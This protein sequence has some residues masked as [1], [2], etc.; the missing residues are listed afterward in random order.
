[1]KILYYNWI[2]FDD[3]SSGGGVNIYQKNIIEEL[4]KKNED[5][6]FFISSGVEYNIL[7][8]E[9]Y[10][11][12]TQNIYANRCRT[13]KII[14]SP[15]PSPGINNMKIWENS[16]VDKKL[17]RIF[18]DFILKYG[19]FNI[20][21][22]NNLEGLAFPVLELKK[23]FPKIKFIYSLHNYYFCC[24]T[25]NLWT[26]DE[27]NCFLLNY[28]DCKKC[29]NSSR[30]LEKIKRIRFKE[31][32]KK[33]FIIL[34]FIDNVRKNLK[35]KLKYRKIA[36]EKKHIKN[37]NNLVFMDKINDYEDWR[38]LGIDIINKNIDI[39]LAVSER[40]REIAIKEGIRN[41]LIQVQYIGTKFANSIN[42][43]ENKKKIKK[44]DEI[45]ICYLGY[46][47][48]DKGYYF[49]LDALEKLENKVGEK[50]NVTLCAKI[51]DIRIMEK[52]KKLEKKLKKVIIINGY[53]HQ[54][55]KNI[56]KDIHLGV[57]PVLWED[58][59]PQV[60]FEFIGYG[61]PV[62]CSNL[63]GAS[64]LAKNKNFIFEGGNINDFNTK[65]KNILENPEI[66]EEFWQDLRKL[67]NVKEHVEDLKSI[68]LQ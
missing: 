12:E 4:I 15:I 17:K 54:D 60:T 49:L 24:P 34:K 11:I 59:L 21:H 22:F 3:F 55:L 48:K 27:K 35:N 23:E 39:I 53:T 51:V 57:I 66:L 45:N 19:E 29:V 2:Q 32:L 52:I 1:M 47:R 10:I 50:V 38:K 33:E 43:I 65:L 5:E 20:I 7:K 31:K 41:E 37:K 13:F 14:N 56:L 62:L 67:K 28:R 40:V 26:T 64:E 61:I 42:T 30:G 18:K 9:P 46:M 68:Y 58:N 44:L 25:V 16:V 36:K 8:K 6:I 63:G